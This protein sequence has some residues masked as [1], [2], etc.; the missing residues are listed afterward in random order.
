M[1]DDD[2]VQNS[3][4]SEQ[5][6]T[7]FEKGD[8]RPSSIGSGALR[9]IHTRSS[10]RK[11]LK[12]HNNRNSYTV[13]FEDPQD[14]DENDDDDN[15][16]NNN[17]S[18]NG[19]DREV[20]KG[21]INKSGGSYIGNSV[22]NNGGGGGIGKW[23]RDHLGSGSKGNHDI[24]P[25]SACKT[26]IINLVNVSYEE[27]YFSRETACTSE[28]LYCSLPRDHG[29]HDYNSIR[30]IF[31]ENDWKSRVQDKPRSSGFNYHEKFIGVDSGGLTRGGS[32]YSSEEPV[33]GLMVSAAPLVNLIFLP[34]SV[35]F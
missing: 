28:N 27:K 10:I 31:H 20:Q 34:H 6:F 25:S 22:E 9:Y 4:H 13:L 23:L 18:G 8:K 11:D 7:M 15:N 2:D 5:W 1:D 3:L 29:R 17:G 21:R 14:D 30:K 24:N 16:S 32:I 12:K 26:N 33:I 19:D 35:L